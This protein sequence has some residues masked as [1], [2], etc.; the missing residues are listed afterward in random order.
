METPTVSSFPASAISRNRHGLAVCG[1]ILLYLYLGIT[2][3]L[4]A[5]SDDAFISLWAGERLAA[6]DGIVNQSL[7][8]VEIC[9]SLLH[10]LILAALAKVAPGYVFTLN[11][12]A[13]LSC[14]VIIL[15]CIY[16]FRE[17][18]FARLKKSK[19]P[20]YA[21][22]LV[23]VAT[24]P[25]FVYWNLGSM[26]TPFVALLLFLY[27]VGLAAHWRQPSLRLATGAALSA[28]LYT[29]VRPEGFYIVLFGVIYAVLFFR[30]HGWRP[31]VCGIPGVPALVFVAITAW[32]FFYLDA[33]F[34]N[35]VYAKTGS[36]IES[37]KDGLVYLWNF[38]G[39]S[40]FIVYALVV[41]AI[42]GL[43]FGRVL[44]LL[45]VDGEEIPRE[46]FDHLF[47][48]GLATTV[49][50]VVVLA[51]GDWMAYFRQFTPVIPLLA[52]L[53]VVFTFA[54]FEAA[55][56]IVGTS[57]ARR[58][59]SAFLGL[60]MAVLAVLN[61]TQ[62]DLNVPR[63]IPWPNRSS[64]SVYS[65]REVFSSL[66]GLDRRMMLLNKEHARDILLTEPFLEDV[67]PGLYAEHGRIV[68]VCGQ[69]GVWPHIIRKH[70][71]DHNITFVDH[72]GLCDRTV[73]RLPLAKDCVGIA[74]G[75]FV[76]EILSGAIPVLSDY[77][78]AQKPHLTYMLGY[79]SDM[80]R[81]VQVLDK[82]GYKL[83]Y[84]NWPQMI[85]YNPNPQ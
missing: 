78:R 1:A 21:A 12:M 83:V 35:P 43:W 33:L 17:D 37:A 48:F 52:V 71:P 73:A 56:D 2:Y 50:L 11:K 23:F 29:M 75:K 25:S 38:S 77:V 40:L 5:G 18:L 76:D 7:E 64:S 42:L 32:R 26:E 9:S 4:G 65:V 3:H 57:G 44:W 45:V 24:N 20:A 85:F 22:T 31:S 28:G 81:R 49:I 41:V 13:G 19:F 67:F 80:D 82:A 62:D 84:E 6:G 14:G 74:Q 39:S 60:L 53:S 66:D 10:T 34:P 68:I 55:N 58:A 30:V 59:L 15:V 69:M 79:V 70:F 27:A 61:A 54:V 8:R 72:L 47:T 16:R 51:G 63:P 36:L 46:R